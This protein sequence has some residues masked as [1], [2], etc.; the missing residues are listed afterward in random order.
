MNHEIPWA[1]GSLIFWI[2]NWAGT[3][4]VQASTET[5]M[6]IGLMHGSLRALTDHIW[7]SC[8]CEL[9]PLAWE[10]NLSSG[11]G[12]GPCLS[13]VAGSCLETIN[14]TSW[15]GLLFFLWHGGH[16]VYFSCC[17]PGLLPCLAG[18]CC[19]LTSWVRLTLKWMYTAAVTEINVSIFPFWC[20][21]S[22]EKMPVSC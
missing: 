3:C 5:T 20:L 7:C 14:W 11:L 17:H 4:S 19:S 6:Q 10:L 16:V 22:A 21:V 12:C 13:N 15:P 1:C 9:H 2:R 8:P 18:S